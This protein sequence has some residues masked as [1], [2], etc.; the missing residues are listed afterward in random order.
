M[1][2][3]DIEDSI[4]VL[5]LESYRVRIMDSDSDDDML[6]DSDFEVEDN[7]LFANVPNNGVSEG[8]VLIAGVSEAAFSLNEM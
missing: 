5:E 6:T 1:N 2:L 8:K 7:Q 3:I 4:D